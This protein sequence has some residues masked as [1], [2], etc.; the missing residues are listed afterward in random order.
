MIK[1]SAGY[2][3]GFRLKMW[4]TSSPHVKLTGDF[5]NAIEVTRIGDCF[6]SR[7]FAKNSQ[8]CNFRLLQHNRPRADM[9]SPIAPAGLLAEP[10][11]HPAQSALANTYE[12]TE[13]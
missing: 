9:R 13:R 6:P 11:C 4:R 5:G 1:N 3:R 12:Y 10:M 8:T 7:V 2:R